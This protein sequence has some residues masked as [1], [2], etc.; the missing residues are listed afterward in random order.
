MHAASLLPFCVS[1]PPA[2]FRAENNFQSYKDTPLKPQK[3]PGNP[4][5]VQYV[6]KHSRLPS[7]ERATF[8]T[9]RTAVTVLQGTTGQ[10]KPTAH[11]AGACPLPQTAP[12]QTLPQ[13]R[14]L[15]SEL[16]QR[17][18][19][20]RALTAFHSTVLPEPGKA[21][22]RSLG[23][24]PLHWCCFHLKWEEERP[25]RISLYNPLR[26]AKAICPGTYNTPPPHEI[27]AP[28]HFLGLPTQ[29]SQT[30]Q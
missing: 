28:F 13:P 10:T 22:T 24:E 16:F 29:L 30:L 3:L 5:Q 21:E 18:E 12:L 4:G 8:Q 25:L 2:F 15:S 17:K 9:N 27:S 19:E 6:W 20:S 7:N 1:A 11:K 26:E 14:P 23:P